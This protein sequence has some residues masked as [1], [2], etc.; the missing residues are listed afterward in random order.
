[1]IYDFNGICADPYCFGFNGQMKVNEM[2]GV[3][4]SLDFTFR[5]YDSSTGRLEEHDE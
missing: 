3:G 2:I 1:M 4:N 5:G